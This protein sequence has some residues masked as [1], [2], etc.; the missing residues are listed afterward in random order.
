MAEFNEV[1]Q[2]AVYYDIVFNRDVSCEVDFIR[3]VFRHHSGRD[4]RSVLDIA[5]GPGYHARAFAQQGVRAVGLDLRGEMLKFA[6]DQAEAE[7]AS[8]EW[9]EADM[10]YVKLAEP[11]D[12]AISMFDGIDALRGK[13]GDLAFELGAH[14]LQRLDVAPQALEL[15]Q[16]QLDLL[17]IGA[18]QCVRIAQLAAQ[19]VGACRLVAGAGGEFGDLGSQR[20][21]LGEGGLELARQGR[22]AG[23]FERQEVARRVAVFAEGLLAVMSAF[24]G[25]RTKQAPS[26]RLGSSA[27]LRRALSV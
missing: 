2:R 27:H 14:R 26:P 12:A 24:R 1:Y 23:S 7:G 17:L 20:V 4:L 8:V 3:D 5:C 19:L 11:V 22:G 25:E 21:A 13:P 6:S 9:I 18:G 15:A 10:R 16:L